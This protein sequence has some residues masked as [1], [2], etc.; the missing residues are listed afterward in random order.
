MIKTT[1]EPYTFGY[2]RVSSDDQDLSQQR[3][4]LM[5]YGVPSDQI[6]CPKASGSKLERKELARVLKILRKGDTLVVWKLDRLGRTL[7]G[8]LKT[9]VKLDNG[10]VDF[11]SITDGIDTAKPMGKALFQFA[12]IMVE[13]FLNGDKLDARCG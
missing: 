9:I 2:T 7:T 8:I 12:K 13:L 10:K 1:P 6:Y 3:D 11:V 5:R 4:S